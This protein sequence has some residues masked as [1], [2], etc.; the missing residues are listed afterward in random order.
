VKGS[1]HDDALVSCARRVGVDG[2]KKAG[3]A[4][5]RRVTP[6]LSQ[7]AIRSAEPKMHGA[8]V[9]GATAKLA[10]A[11]SVGDRKS[12]DANCAW[13]AAKDV[14]AATSELWKHSRCDCTTRFQ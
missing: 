8:C 3:E 12:A 2:D 11:T 4:C 14:D 9:A 13:V 7:R 6:A 5:I 10:D 1:A